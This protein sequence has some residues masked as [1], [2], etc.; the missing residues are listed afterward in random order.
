MLNF[1]P[2]YKILLMMIL[3]WI[4]IITNAKSIEICTMNMLTCYTDSIP[5]KKRLNFKPVPNPK[6]KSFKP[7]NSIY[8]AETPPL[9]PGCEAITNKKEQ[10]YCTTQ[11]LLT[12]IYDRGKYP[13]VARKNGVEGVVVIKFEVDTT[14]VILNPKIA[15]DIGAGCGLEALRI[16]KLMPKWIPA[17]LGGKP[18][19]KPY[20]LPI[21][22]KL[23]P[24]ENTEK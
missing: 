24:A 11:K 4:S 19:K 20:Y 9:F 18:I 23:E 12:F 2:L 3:L 17:T 10:L 1:K 8:P 13:T 14:G 6:K 15:R 21:R 22:F 5:N 16:V 7:E